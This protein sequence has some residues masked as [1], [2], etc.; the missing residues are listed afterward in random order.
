MSKPPI[1]DIRFSSSSIDDFFSPPTRIRKASTGKVRVANIGQLQ[2]AF[3]FV[4]SETLIHLSKQDFWKLGQ[5]DDGFFV[6]RLVSDDD[7][8]LKEWEG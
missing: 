3:Q 6:E 8:P 7:G 2:S 4:G 1:E 5:D